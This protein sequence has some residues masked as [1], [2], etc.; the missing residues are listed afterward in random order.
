MEGGEKGGCGG[1]LVLKPG[2]GVAVTP[3]GGGGEGGG[4]FPVARV[5]PLW[6]SA[7]GGNVCDVRIK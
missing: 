5:G 4:C 6:S 7:G 2:L 3:A 1:W